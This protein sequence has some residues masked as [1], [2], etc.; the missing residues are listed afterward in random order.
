MDHLTRIILD[1]RAILRSFPKACEVSFLTIRLI[2][3][4]LILTKT[5][6]MCAL[7][8]PVDR[9]E[10]IE[11]GMNG[12]RE[13][14]LHMIGNAMSRIFDSRLHGILHWVKHLTDMGL[15]HT[16]EVFGITKLLA[17][18]TDR[19]VVKNSILYI[20]NQ[21]HTGTTNM[22]NCAYNLIVDESHCLIYYIK[23][24][25]NCF[26]DSLGC[27]TNGCSKDL[28]GSLNGKANRS[29]D[30]LYSSTNDMF[31]TLHERACNCIK[32]IDRSSNDCLSSS[33]DCRACCRSSFSYRSKNTSC[34][35]NHTT[36][37][38]FLDVLT[39]T[40][41]CIPDRCCDITN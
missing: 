18:P 1:F 27:K 8:D 21:L 36:K 13:S 23:R 4:I 17:D 25:S 2:L 10:K 39:D 33:P 12:I 30:N 15:H 29:C 19:T 28:H 31:C 24:K 37:E 9:I 14:L 35:I 22:G 6:E 5:K 3:I 32:K 38:V 34:S 7:L 41:C 26:T 20:S 40:L 11:E 16:H